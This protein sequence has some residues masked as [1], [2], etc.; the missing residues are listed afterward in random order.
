MIGF[1]IAAAVLL[2]IT[3][4]AVTGLYIG[5]SRQVRS[6]AD[7]LPDTA[8]STAVESGE[9]AP[10]P[11]NLAP[12]LPALSIVITARD[13]VADIEATVGHALAQVYPGLEVI[14]VDDRST[15]GTGEVLDRLVATVGAGRL[16]VTH[17]RAL[18]AG[19]IGKC[20]ACHEGARLAR[21][22]FLL[23]MDGDVTL[24]APDLLARIV[25]WM[26]RGAIDHLA[27][28]PD[29][30]PYGGLQAGLLHS[31]EQAMLL[32]ARAWEMERDLPRGGAGVGAFNL[33]RR[34]AYDRVHGHALL[35]MEVGDD[36]KLGM[37][38]KESG[39][40]QRIRGGLGLVRCRWH[41]GTLAVLRGLEKN[42]F[43]GSDYSLGLLAAQTA[44]ML[45]LHGGPLLVGLAAGTPAGWLPL[46]TQAGCVV[47]AAASASRRID[48]HPLVLAA[49]Y[50][51]SFMLLTV[52]VWNSALRTLWRG[53]VRWRDTFYP[54]ADL[55]RGLVHRGAG[56][57]L[58][59]AGPGAIIQSP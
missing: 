47:A 48:K 18:P 52:A 57:R 42:M 34:S 49:L 16:R 13:E 20:H 9:A 1:L 2:V 26:E 21:G 4:L 40:R 35:R 30:R 23:F 59:G 10:A 28:F 58:T 55:R 12:A 37:L 6:M 31:F 46:A 50:P 24:A 56:R 27:L 15:D 8:P 45:A 33:I 29:L 17:V 14:V 53:G 38:L 44:A 43:S 32:L 51:V 36:F 5:A 39:A 41:R 3:W 25:A 54:L 19:W 22:A 11:G 7:A